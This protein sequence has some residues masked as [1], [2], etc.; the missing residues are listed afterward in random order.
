MLIF[1]LVDILSFIIP[2]LH[3]FLVEFYAVLRRILSRKKNPADKF[4]DVVQAA[5]ARNPNILAR[6]YADR[7]ML[8]VLGRGLGNR[9]LLPHEVGH[10]VLPALTFKRQ[11]SSLR[12]S[13]TPKVRTR[14]PTALTRSLTLR[15]ERSKHAER[16]LSEA[17]S[18]EII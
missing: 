1:Q 18:D 3:D 6:K 8:A 12:R 7:W 5:Q 17:L 16:Q 14:K 13:I 15:R 11:A 2:P 4:V 9:L 10:S